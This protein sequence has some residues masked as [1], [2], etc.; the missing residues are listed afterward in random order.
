MYIWCFYRPHCTSNA[1]LVFA[2]SAMGGGG[3]EHGHGHD[4]H[5]KIDNF[6]DKYAGFRPPRVKYQRLTVVLGTITW[7]W[8]FW[9]AKHDGLGF[10][11]GV[12]E[13]FGSFSLAS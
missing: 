4:A 10:L 13:V 7:L 6:T 3:H 2:L 5:A 9:R 1:N 8:L 11:T 12:C